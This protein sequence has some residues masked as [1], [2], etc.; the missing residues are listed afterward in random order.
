MVKREDVKTL[1]LAVA[2]F[3]SVSRL[4]W[5]SLVCTYR[6]VSAGK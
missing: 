3:L 1:D 2:L 4:G 6:E 5:R